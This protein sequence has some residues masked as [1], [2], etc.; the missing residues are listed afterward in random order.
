MKIITTIASYKI[1]GNERG[2]I[3]TYIE[4]IKKI[5][6]EM[7]KTINISNILSTIIKI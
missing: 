7:M 4:R 6:T 3:L 2:D 1:T 5:K